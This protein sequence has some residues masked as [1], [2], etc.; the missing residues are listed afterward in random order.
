MHDFQNAIIDGI[1]Y[2]PEEIIP[3]GKI[4][5]FATSDKSQDK[6][7]YYCLFEHG[8]GLQAGFYG[9]W[10][11]PESY[12]TWH[13]QN[14]AKLTD[15]QREW[16]RA[17]KEKAEVERSRLAEDAAAEAETIWNNA[18]PAPAD[19]PYLIKKNI[20]PCGAR[21]HNNK[22]LLKV[23]NADG[24]I[25]S[26]Q[27]IDDGGN[28]RFLTD[29]KVRGGFF[30]IK[31]SGA[32]GPVFIC[33]GFAT[34][35]S[36]WEAMNGKHT[37][38]AAFN[39]GN[40]QPV[41]EA[42]RSKS[43]DREIVICS[44]NDHKTDGNPGMAY[45]R[46]TALAVNAKLT[47]PEFDSGD[48]GTDFNDLATSKGLEAVS[49]RIEQADYPSPENQAESWPD[50]IP[51]SQYDVPAINADDLPL[52]AGSMVR[53]ISDSLQVPAELAVT[54]VL[55]AVSLAVIGCVDEVEVK[56]GYSET[57]NL[58]LLAELPPAE[59][60]S[61]TIAISFRPIYA[62]ES[63]QAE[64]MRDKIR[65]A[66]SK[67]K[68][69]EKVID[70]RRSKLSR[71][72]DQDKLNEEI[73]SIS[74]SEASLPDVPKSPRLIFDDSTNERVPTLLKDNN[75]VAGIVSAEGGMFDTMAGRYSKGIP[76]LDVYLK[77]H[78]GEP[79]SVD[80]VG[81]EPLVLLKPRLVICLCVQN[82]V[83]E[84]LS[85][86][87]GFRGRGVIGRFIYILPDSRLGHRKIDTRAMSEKVIREYDSGIRSLLD[88]RGAG[89]KL[90]LSPGAYELWKQFAQAVEVELRPGGQFEAMTDWAGKLPGAAARIAG[91]F[92][93]IS[94][95]LPGNLTVSAEIMEQ[96]LSLSSR[97]ADHAREAIGQMGC[98]DSR[99]AALRVLKWIRETSSTR[100]TARSCYKALHGTLKTMAEVKPGLDTLE[101]RGYIR[102]V[103]EPPSG[104]GRPSKVFEVNPEVVR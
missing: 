35:A 26:Y 46:K 45:A 94:S 57:L 82:E 31:G 20:K 71:I 55:G 101:E 38:L 65:A 79:V 100:F 5:R 9:D 21:L 37:V 6:A 52:W 89:L 32:D 69:L 28:K 33:E 27:T 90:K 68:S 62:W 8:D 87:P 97:L 49:L 34:A 23:I 12:L 30:S 102:K 86:K 48:F 11:N 95:S 63:E 75:E 67:R 40:L 64:D 72:K 74:K 29:G 51:F 47:W 59:R 58:Y 61:G 78:C 81:R 7:G 19:C 4:H 42:V 92:H 39:A 54:T 56:T 104:P 84:S 83:M 60:K 25:Q 17:A 99:A 91:L 85:S 93:C 66:R 50:L 98:D 16:V 36:V 70:Q 1:G 43:P 22:L 13:S 14:G 80:R 3:D 2:G 103:S 53:E 18:G 44:D 76:N 96:A 15:Q 73:E 24:K 77:A 10:R 41:A 88:L